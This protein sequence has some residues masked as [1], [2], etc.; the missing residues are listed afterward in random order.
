[1][2]WA[3]VSNTFFSERKKRCALLRLIVNQTPTVREQTNER[4]IENK[5]KLGEIVGPSTFSLTIIN[6]SSQYSFSCPI[7]FY[8]ALNLRDSPFFYMAFESLQNFRLVYY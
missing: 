2:A 8:I 5:K 6:L 7:F 1:M 3:T 4:R